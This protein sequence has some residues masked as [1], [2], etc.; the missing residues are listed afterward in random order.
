MRTMLLLTVVALAARGTAQ[1]QT[2]AR[3][4]VEQRRALANAYRSAELLSPP[5]DSFRV[6]WNEVLASCTSC[7]PAFAFDDVSWFTLPG[8]TVPCVSGR[9]AGTF[10][11]DGGTVLLAERRITDKATVQHEMV[12]MVLGWDPE[13]QHYIWRLYPGPADA[14]H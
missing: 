1:A 4:Q 2:L 8:F 7:E 5:P 12:H 14:K 13:H 6:W 10:D 3:T 11:L 9:C